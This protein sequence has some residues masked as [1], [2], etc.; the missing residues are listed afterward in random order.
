MLKKIVKL[1]KHK[2]LLQA[3]SKKVYRPFSVFFKPVKANFKEGIYQRNIIN[4]IKYGPAAPVYNETLWVQANQVDKIL[5]GLL[6]K[7]HVDTKIQKETF[8]ASGIVLSSELPFLEALSISEFMRSSYYREKR[9]VNDL[10]PLYTGVM[11]IVVC[12]DHWVYGTPWEKTGIYDFMEALIE[13]K[14]RPVDSCSDRKDI[15]QRYNK[16][17]LIFEQV[18]KEG[19]LRLPEEVDACY[20][21]GSRKA[22]SFGLIHL[23]P[24][25]ELSWGGGASHRR[26][27]AHVLALPYPAK[28]GLV[29]VSA[30]PRLKTMR[31]QKNPE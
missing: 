30:M 22:S 17:D 29:H 21:S 19:R 15:I 13:Y 11:K 2:T 24:E 5:P 27:I 31:S 23:G 26:A 20:F 6:L 8:N 16:L 28:I 9:W 18:K 25:G 1:I 3:V 12:I 7:K 4:K 14:G 10:N